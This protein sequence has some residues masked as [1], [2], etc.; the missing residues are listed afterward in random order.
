[1]PYL[2]I[3]REFLA[4]LQ[5]LQQPPFSVAELTDAY[6]AVPSSAHESKKAARQFVYRNMLRLISAGALERI[7]SGKRWPVYKATKMFLTRLD[8]FASPEQVTLTPTPAFNAP[9][10]DELKERLNHHKLEMLTAMGE[11][12]EYD[13]ICQEWP[14]MQV[15]LQER[16]NLARDRCSRLLGRLKALENLLA[17]ASD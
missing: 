8:T 5:Q 7:S 4:A 1:M 10:R 2:S 12:E 15:E 17:K 16:Y 9:S 14:E 3:S 13:A 11:A 6:M